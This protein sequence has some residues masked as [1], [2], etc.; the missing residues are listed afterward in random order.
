MGRQAADAGG[1]AARI[2]PRD[3]P[4]RGWWTVLRRA[5]ASTDRDNVGLLA[6]G[7]AYYGLFALFPALTALMAISALVID[8]AIV[9]DEIGGSVEFLPEGAD[10][11]IADQAA[12]VAA[13]QQGGLGFAA[14]AG[15]AVALY[16]SSRAVSSLMQGMN[17]AWGARETR[18]YVRRTA[19]RLVL[20]ALL[21]AGVAV[22]LFAML[23]LPG[24][25]SL[26]DLGLVTETLIRVTR[27]AVLIGLTIGG[28]LLLYRGG[29]NRTAGGWRWLMPG[30]LVA[31]AVW[32]LASMAF[33]WYVEAFGSY[34][35]TFGALGGVVVLLLWFFHGPCEITS[36]SRRLSRFPPIRGSVCLRGTVQGPPGAPE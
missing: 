29:P 5:F 31:C 6:A 22:A 7:V 26:V 30:A 16:S 18:G 24:L 35:E 33:S 21:I 15:I 25:L 4:A 34:N 9:A 11:I 2:G 10:T 27:W 1:D 3:I 20:T 32:I 36:N 23:V 8:P 14:L 17:V 12:E 13:A 28:I 19:T